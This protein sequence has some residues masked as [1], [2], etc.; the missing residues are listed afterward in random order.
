MTATPAPIIPHPGPADDSVLVEDRGI[1]RW[2]TINREKVRNALNDDVLTRL[3][4]GIVSA[5]EVSGLRAIVL[6]GAGDSAFCAGGDLKPDSKTFEFDHSAPTTPLGNLLRAAYGCD[7]P[8][9]ARINGH[10]MAGGMGLLTMA[11]MA[12][13]SD[14][15]LFG[16]PEVKIG[17]FPMQVSALL[18]SLISRRKFAELCLTGEPIGA[19]E[20][21][22]IGLVNYVTPIGELD[23]RTDWLIDRLVGKSPTAIRRGKHALRATRNMTIEQAISFMETQLATL[24][25][26][27][28]SIEGIA[29]F[30]EKR[31]PRWTG[32]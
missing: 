15:A 7:L 4:V 14:N 30:N 22:D 26:T 20:A 10:C 5:R 24:A 27:E 11:D 31:P 16:L 13:A 17:M 19:A 6:T 1:V 21:L 23:A 9:I 29:A 12:V 8:I 3:A 32:R 25:L 28:D 18:Q 2:L